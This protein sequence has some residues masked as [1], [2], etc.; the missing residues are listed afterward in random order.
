MFFRPDCCNP[1]SSAT[2][3]KGEKTMIETS[4]TVAGFSNVLEH[5]QGLDAGNGGKTEVFLSYLKEEMA[6]SDDVSAGPDDRA[7]ADSD[8]EKAAEYNQDIAAIKEKGIVAF[9]IEQREKRIREEILASMGLTEEALAEMPPEQRARIE[10]I[11]AE[12]IKKRMS[13]ETL[14]QDNKNRKS[15]TARLMA[16]VTM[17]MGPGIF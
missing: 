16:A 3:L 11:I 12:E 2:D 8:T 5:N 4:C 1:F 9:I 7:A 17:E 6:V 10:K 15:D 13:A 14:M